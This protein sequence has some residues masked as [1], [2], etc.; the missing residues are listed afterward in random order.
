[1]LF[2]LLCGMIQLIKD[3]R[4]NTVT[5]NLHWET[6]QKINC[7][8]CITRNMQEELSNFVKNLKYQYKIRN[9]HQKTFC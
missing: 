8:N 7:T 4:K 2:Q 6:I 9:I 5:Q 3:L 1:M